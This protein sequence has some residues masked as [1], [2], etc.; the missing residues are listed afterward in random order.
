ML[1]E[2]GAVI[3]ANSG[4]RRIVQR[5]RG[6]ANVP[7]WV[8]RKDQLDG[9]ASATRLEVLDRLVTL[10]P[11]SAKEMSASLGRHLNTAYYHLEAMRS[12]QLVHRTHAAPR[13]GPGRREAVYAAAGV[14]IR[15][16]CAAGQVANRKSMVR[17]AQVVANQAAKEYALGFNAQEWRIEGPTRNHCYFRG[18][19]RLSATR[20]ASIN[21]LLDELSRLMSTPD[22]APGRQTISVA[23][24]LAPRCARRPRSRANGAGPRALMAPTRE[25]VLRHS[26]HRAEPEMQKA[27]R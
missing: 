21:T 7:Y 27:P 17:I 8:M 18:L 5:P 1:I 4:Q 11:M 6:A 16:A 23:W 2:R 3:A 12:L 9:L 25:S 26:N 13:Q 19:V 20:L 14:P 10:G 24:F 15:F 22:P